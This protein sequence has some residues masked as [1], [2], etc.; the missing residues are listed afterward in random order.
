MFTF[1]RPKR[2]SDGEKLKIMAAHKNLF[3]KVL[4][5]VK[6]NGLDYEVSH[7]TGTTS[8]YLTVYINGTDNDWH[9]EMRCRFADHAT[10]NEGF[11]SFDSSIHGNAFSAVKP[12]LMQCVELN[13]K[14]DPSS[15]FLTI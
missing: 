1:V 12:Q 10:P 5:F 15:S 11:H 9:G 6:S 7:A 8:S 2:L 14:I 13:G 3:K 4:E